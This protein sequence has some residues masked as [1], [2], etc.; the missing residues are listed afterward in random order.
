M[1]AESTLRITEHPI[2]V[3]L[4]HHPNIGIPLNS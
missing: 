4:P 3:S 2:T 1:L